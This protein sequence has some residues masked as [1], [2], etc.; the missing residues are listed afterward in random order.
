MKKTKFSLPIV[1]ITVFTI[2]VSLSACRSQ[3]N[4]S[5][6]EVATPLHEVFPKKPCPSTPTPALKPGS[7]I[8]LQI[9]PEPIGFKRIDSLLFLGVND[10]SHQMSHVAV[11]QEQHYFWLERICYDENGKERTEVLDEIVLPPLQDSEFA[12]TQCRIVGEISVLTAATGNYQK[13]IT[14]AWTLDSEKWK[15]EEVPSDRLDQITCP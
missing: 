4:M 12:S 2:V 8:G 5:S 10:Y 13:G 1:L 11:S 6:T 9:P 14:Q 15:F 3:D 7:Y